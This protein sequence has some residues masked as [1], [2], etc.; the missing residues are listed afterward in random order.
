[1]TIS[2]KEISGYLNSEILEMILINSKISSAFNY[3]DLAITLSGKS[4]RHH[5]PGSSVLLETIDGRMNQQEAVNKI[6]NVAK[7][8]HE[9]P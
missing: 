5:I 3:D 9:T 8:D 6:P 2:G 1:M 4:Y 7:F